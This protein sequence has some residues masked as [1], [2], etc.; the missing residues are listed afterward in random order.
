MR[1]GG[2][3]VKYTAYIY[4]NPIDTEFGIAHISV[5]PFACFKYASPRFANSFA[6]T[7]SATLSNYGWSNNVLK[8][9]STFS[10]V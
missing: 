3:G 7:I 8:L 6:K 10:I 9:R 5:H 4:V 1:A 2:N